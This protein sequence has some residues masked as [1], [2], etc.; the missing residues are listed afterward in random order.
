MVGIKKILLLPLILLDEEMS[1]YV[2]QKRRTREWLKRREEKG[3]YYTNFKEL[4]VEDTPGF[5]KIF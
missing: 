3:A 1:N 4:A 5:A 2:D